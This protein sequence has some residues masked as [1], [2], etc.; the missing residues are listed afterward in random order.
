V[1]DEMPAWCTLSIQPVSEGVADR[2]HPRHLAGTG[3]IT[4]HRGE[5]L[6]RHRRLGQTRMRHALTLRRCERDQP[7]VRLIDQ[8]T[9]LQWRGGTVDQCEKR[10]PMGQMAPERRHPRIDA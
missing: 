2:N 5:R 9:R 3:D 8:S 7:H 4:G 1:E 10:W 6:A